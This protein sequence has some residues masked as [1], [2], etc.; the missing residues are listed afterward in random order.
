[1]PKLSQQT[2]ETRFQCPHCG[3]T[4]RTRSGLS[5][6]IQFKHPKG[7]SN[8]PKSIADEAYDLK[9]MEI[10]LRSIGKS[11][12]EIADLT[13][14]NKDW[15]MTRSWMEDDKFKLKNTDF[16]TFQLISYAVMASEKRQKAWLTNELGETIKQ[17]LMLNTA[18]TENLQRQAH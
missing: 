16:R 2:L 7:L 15:L 12:A 9:K 14:V 5:G 18:I 6:H 8:K 3:I 1:M 10:F 17:L 13:Q 4:L 11:D